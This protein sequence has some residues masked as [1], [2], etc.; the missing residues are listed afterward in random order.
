MLRVA[1]A[2]YPE[3]LSVSFTDHDLRITYIDES[4]GGT[5]DKPHVDRLPLQDSA[6]GNYFCRRRHNDKHDHVLEDV[7]LI[8]HCYTKTYLLFGWITIHLRIS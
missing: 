1:V 5:R 4:K 6:G 7:R 2:V 3:H 8:E